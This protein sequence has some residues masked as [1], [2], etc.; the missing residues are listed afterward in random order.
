VVETARA[1]HDDGAGATRPGTVQG[2]LALRL[3]ST[4]KR[5]VFQMVI[6]RRHRRG[7]E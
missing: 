4:D 5:I 7:V 2:V 3:I 1:L 6:G